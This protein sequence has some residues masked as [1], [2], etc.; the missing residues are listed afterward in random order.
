M[1]PCCILLAAL[2]ELANKRLSRKQM[3]GCAGSIRTLGITAADIRS[4]ENHEDA[5]KQVPSSLHLVHGIVPRTSPGTISVSTAPLRES[6]L[7][8]FPLFR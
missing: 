5:H 7:C 4:R 1:L 8:Y 3:P 6:A 2:R